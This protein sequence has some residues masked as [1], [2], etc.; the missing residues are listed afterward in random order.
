M[1]FKKQTRNLRSV[2]VLRLTQLNEEGSIKIALQL[3]N[4]VI[5]RKA[6]NDMKKVTLV[7]AL[8]FS[9][10][11]LLG[12]ASQGG[13]SSK[14]HTK[15]NSIKTLEKEAGA[16]SLAFREVYALFCSI[17]AKFGKKLSKAENITEFIRLA[18][19][20][21]AA[22]DLETRPDTQSINEWWNEMVRRLEYG[23]INYKT[24]IYA[25]WGDIRWETLIKLGIP[26]WEGKK[27]RSAWA[28][29]TDDL[30]PS[31][32][33]VME[34][35][36]L[37]VEF[38]CES[39]PVGS[40]PMKFIGWSTFGDEPK[41]VDP[42]KSE[43][44][45]RGNNPNPE[46]AQYF[47][48]LI[49][50][51]NEPPEFTAFPGLK[52][53]IK[54]QVEFFSLLGEEDSIWDVYCASITPGEQFSMEAIQQGSFNSEL[55]AYQGHNLVG[56]SAKRESSSL[57]SLSS[58]TED[59]IKERGFRTYLSTPNLGPGSYDVIF[60]IKATESNLGVSRKTI[61]LPPPKSQAIG[62]VSNLI[63]CF[64]RGVMGGEG[65]ERHGIKFWPNPTGTLHIGEN[66][67]GYVEFRDTGRVQVE[68]LLLPY[69]T[70]GRGRKASTV[71]P[72][73]EIVDTT[74]RY[75]KKLALDLEKMDKLEGD[76]SI[77]L[78]HREVA[79]GGFVY[80]PLS[81]PT[82]TKG[83]YILAAKISHEGKPIG[84]AM[85]SVT[86]KDKEVPVMRS[87]V[88]DK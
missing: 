71:G 26:S 44:G 52:K 61:E 41:V 56:S 43:E 85:A 69:K 68:W 19:E 6:R 29:N 27:E 50:I 21:K 58:L 75:W 81:V 13:G 48:E 11:V 53:V 32:I 20:Y 66:F 5:S 77:S 35:D 16:D 49:R 46:F 64:P 9:C 42:L 62:K 79:T 87:E 72:I 45:G 31:Q 84:L 86:I 82:T 17:D 40:Y 30:M 18:E 65:I 23:R 2:F 60:S 54:S 83:S 36:S 76:N 37:G 33:W 38:A 73:E 14:S 88:P 63:V 51:K 80:Q 12:C 4:S 78:G 34:W 10:L 1:V 28:G 22:K 7:G 70:D 15:R 3:F 59:V 24:P 47:K 39:G 67:D 25:S 57:S 74:G 55:L 8:L